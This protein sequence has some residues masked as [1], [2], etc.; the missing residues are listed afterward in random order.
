ME[1]CAGFGTVTIP[2]LTM[3]Y[4]G[5]RMSG[6]ACARAQVQHKQ[7]WCTSAPYTTGYKDPNRTSEGHIWAYLG[8]PYFGSQ[9]L[10][11]GAPNSKQSAAIG[12]QITYPRVGACTTTFLSQ[13]SVTQFEAASAGGQH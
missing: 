13:H 12:G 2:F 5:E 8:T 4:F 6:G 10:V 7:P 9:I 1:A 3:I 11:S